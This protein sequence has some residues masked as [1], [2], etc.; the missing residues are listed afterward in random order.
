MKYKNY[1]NHTEYMREWRKKN[2]HKTRLYN[3]RGK[4]R[5]K[6]WK[7]EHKDRV[8]IHDHTSYI[9]NREKHRLRHYAYTV[10]RDKYLII[11]PSCVYCG[12][13]ERLELHHIDYEEQN[14]IVLCRKCHTK[15]HS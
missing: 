14:I 12:S 2:K 5:V 8:A 9:N 3:T 4:E 11:F 6:K 7:E 10:L 13:K 15:Q 1:K